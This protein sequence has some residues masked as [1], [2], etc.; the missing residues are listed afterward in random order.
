MMGHCDQGGVMFPT[1]SSGLTSGFVDGWKPGRG[2]RLTPGDIEALG[3]PALAKAWR[4]GGAESG[5]A[6]RETY[7]TAMAAGDAAMAEVLSKRAG[8]VDALMRSGGAGVVAVQTS[9]KDGS[10]TQIMTAAEFEGWKRGEGFSSDEPGESEPSK[11]AR[12][13]YDAVHKL[14]IMRMVADQ[15]A[16]MR[17]A[18]EDQA[19]AGT[20]SGTEAAKD[21][22][23]GGSAVDETARKS[24]TDALGDGWKWTMAMSGTTSDGTRVTVGVISGVDTSRLPPELA[25]GSSLRISA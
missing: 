19:T 8:V 4:E 10:V 20:E 9:Y 24:L 3:L 15:L 2:E 18:D 1:V 23:Q 21:V 6:I 7:E 25:R 17:A 12:A 5:D 16:Q 22:A 14:S 13:S 11:G